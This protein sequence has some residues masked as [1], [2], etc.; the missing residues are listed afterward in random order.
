MAAW[1]CLA[2]AFCFRATSTVSMYYSKLGVCLY[3]YRR[4]WYLRFFHCHFSTMCDVKHTYTEFIPHTDEGSSQHVNA[5]QRVRHPHHIHYHMHM[6]P[7]HTLLV[8]VPIFMLP[9]LASAGRATEH[10]TYTTPALWN[11]FTPAS[12]PLDT[13]P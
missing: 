8:T 9:L 3:L 4:T 1:Y 11:I 10:H 2:T 13:P 5:S 12:L 7:G 6:V